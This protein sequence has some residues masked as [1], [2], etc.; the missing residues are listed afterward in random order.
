VCVCSCC[1]ILICG[2]IIK[3]MPGSV[4]SGT[5]C[6]CV[7]IYIYI[8]IYRIYIYIEREREEGGEIEIEGEIFI[9][10][11]SLFVVVRVCTI[12]LP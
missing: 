5:H 9:N 11:R 3:I 7:Y 8:Y 6:V 12:I 1:N 2:K 10:F 4:A